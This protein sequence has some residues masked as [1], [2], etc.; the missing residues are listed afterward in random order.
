MTKGS[1]YGTEVAGKWWRRYREKGFFAR[2]NG[3]FWMDESG[4]HFR[5]LLTSTPLSIRWDE[6]TDA[7]LGKSHAGRWAAGRPVVKV[8][9]VRNELDLCA[10]FQLSPDWPTME[11]FARD[12]TARSNLVE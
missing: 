9:F 5:K 4:I 7:H 1:Y 2:G 11:Q 3:E 10:G 6:I 8:G 12:I